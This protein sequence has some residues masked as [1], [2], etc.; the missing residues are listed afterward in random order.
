MTLAPER[1][2]DQDNRPTPLHLRLQDLRHIHAL[3]VSDPSS[4][5][6]RHDIKTIDANPSFVTDSYHVQ[7]LYHSP[8]DPSDDSSVATTSSSS[9]TDISFD[10]IYPMLV[11][12]LQVQEMTPE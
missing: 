3:R 12:R 7:R 2:T 9:G 10:H 4:P 6:F 11:H 1:R 5:S 8:P